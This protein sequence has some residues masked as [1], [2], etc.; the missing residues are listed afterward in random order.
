MYWWYNP[1]KVR[2]NQQ[3]QIQK[4]LIYNDVKLRKTD[5]TLTNKAVYVF[6]SFTILLYVRAYLAPVANQTSH[7]VSHL[8]SDD[9]TPWPISS[10][11][12][13][14]QSDISTVIIIIAAIAITVNSTLKQRDIQDVPPVTSSEQPACC[15]FHVTS[16]KTKPEPHGR[17]FP[18]NCPV[19]VGMI[20]LKNIHIFHCHLHGESDSNMPVNVL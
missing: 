13:V 19:A 4:Y 5:S 10:H 6:F 7:T 11:E 20:L 18:R 8:C 3:A 16:Q 1:V 12:T 17:I 2:P 14:H 9:Q 15:I